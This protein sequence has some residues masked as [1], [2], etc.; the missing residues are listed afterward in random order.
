MPDPLLSIPPESCRLLFQIR[1]RGDIR[2]EWAGI[3]L[4]VL[5]FSVSAAMVENEDAK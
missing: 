3:A 1:D 4:R 2:R 5:E